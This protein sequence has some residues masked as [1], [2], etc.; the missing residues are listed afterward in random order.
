MPK[1]LILGGTGKL[2]TALAT[3]FHADHDIIALGS[4]DVDATD[5]KS[6]TAAIR[7][8]APDIVANCIAALG[9]DAC[10]KAPTRAYRINALL[11]RHLA[12]L[13]RGH[14]FHLIHFS[15][16]SVFDNAKGAAY[17]ETDLPNPLN[18]YGFTKYAADCLVERT[19][20]NA[21]IFRLPMLFG[22]APKARQFVER[23]LERA[24]MGPATIHVST[25]VHTSPS[26]S[27]D[28]AVEVRRVMAAALL[29]GLYHVANSG[30]T[31]L[32]DLMREIVDHL[33]VPLTIERGSNADF[34]G[35]GEK[36]LDTALASNKLPPLRPWQEAVADY[37]RTIRSL[38]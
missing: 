36:N 25:D 33:D 18:V 27:L 21:Y 9:V 23:M 22:P 19:Q 37:C 38:R 17:V 1:L 13:S 6:I 2:G 28:V 14:G 32:Y 35:I 26:Y 29:G 20:P 34:P 7:D 8:S 11:P 4:A 16:E 31:S 10:E 15:T 12:F 24:A 30:R 3:A 5:L